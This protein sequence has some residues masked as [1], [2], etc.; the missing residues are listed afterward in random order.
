MHPRLEREASTTVQVAAAADP[1]VV[2]SGVLGRRRV[3]DLP[4]P[5]C[6]APLPAHS[7]SPLM[8]GPNRACTSLCDPWAGAGLPLIAEQAPVRFQSL[9]LLLVLLLAQCV[10]GA[11]GCSGSQLAQSRRNGGRVAG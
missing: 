3:E 9:A 1:Q 5:Q 4:E 8:S 7:F 11:R 2:A 10:V 6:L